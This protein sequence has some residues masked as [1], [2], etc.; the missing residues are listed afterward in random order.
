MSLINSYISSAL[1]G[2][3]MTCNT[4]TRF[5]FGDILCHCAPLDS[6]KMLEVHSNPFFISDQGKQ[7]AVQIGGDFYHDGSIDKA[8]DGIASQPSSCK[9][10]HFTLATL[11]YAKMTPQ[12]LFDESTI[13]LKLLH[14]Y[15][16]VKFT[17]AIDE[18][19]KFKQVPLAD[20]E[21]PRATVVSNRTS[22]VEPI[23]SVLNNAHVKFRSRAYLHWYAKYGVEDDQFLHAFQQVDQ[24]C[25]DY[26]SIRV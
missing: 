4:G 15:K 12:K 25:Y 3:L 14:R 21:A 5:D 13:A 7:K 18:V 19:F 23:W 17:G 16:P 24:I 10:A 8:I 6:L 9:D 22:I 2:I 26:F 1:E 20:K 11:C